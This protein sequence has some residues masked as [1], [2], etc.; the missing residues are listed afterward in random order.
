[1]FDQY[2]FILSTVSDVGGRPLLKSALAIKLHV[3]P[4]MSAMFK[5]PS[6][7]IQYMAGFSR[8]V[9]SIVITGITDGL[10]GQEQSSVWLKKG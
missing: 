6:R 5:W 4:L 3:Q 10:Y 9:L 8:M 2:M 1:M 7:E